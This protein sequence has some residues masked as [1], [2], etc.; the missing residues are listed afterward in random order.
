MRALILAAGEG[1]RLRP[2]TQI[3]P[4]PLVPV[5]GVPLIVRQILALK[6]AGITDIVAN[7][8]YGGKIL[9]QHLGDGSAWGVRLRYSV[10][11]NSAAEALETRGGIVRALPMLAETDDEAFLV[12]AGDILTRYDYKNLIARGER[13][14]SEG[15]DAHLVL[16][17]NPVYHLAGDMTVNERGLVAEIPKKYTF[18]SLGVYRRGL[19]MG[20]SAERA[21]L[22]PWLWRFVAQGRVSGEVFT[23]DWVNVGDPTELEA[24][25]RRFVTETKN[26]G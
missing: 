18:S 11:G 22:F 23:G 25:E 4:K 10:E 8:A 9:M 14:A 15:L 26:L 2:L 6:K 7:V 20:L 13:L 1:R 3:M 12:V 21:S 24:A 5:A 16:V 17:P 19:F